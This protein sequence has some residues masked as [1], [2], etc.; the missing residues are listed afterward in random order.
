MSN[1][2]FL[3]LDAVAPIVKKVKLNGKEYTYHE[4][5]VQDFAAE[6]QR[7]EDNKSKLKELEGLTEGD[8]R[9]AGMRIVMEEMVASIAFAF[10]DMSEDVLQSLTL[11][12]ATAITEFIRGKLE[13]TAD[14]AEDPEGNG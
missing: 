13:E 6:M 5:T 14:K 12:Q 10:P 2:E 3:D 7:L 1:S 8:Q 11:K 9:A 4:P